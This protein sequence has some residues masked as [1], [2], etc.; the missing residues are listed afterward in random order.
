MKKELIIKVEEVL[1]LL[2][3]LLSKERFIAYHDLK[4]IYISFLETLNKND[5]LRKSDFLIIQNCMRI[6]FEAPPSPKNKEIG[7][8]I[9]NK[10][11]EI[12]KIKMKIIS[13]ME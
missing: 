12:Y 7:L 10:M 11:D 8:E 1:E 9:L 5:N 4:K 2:D 3:I 13:E 6:F